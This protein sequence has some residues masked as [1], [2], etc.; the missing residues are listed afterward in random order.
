[1]KQQILFFLLLFIS[2]CGLAQHQN[3]EGKWKGVL[4][5]DTGQNRQAR[6][7]I[8][9]SIQFRQS[10]NAVWGIYVR[11][12]NA[13]IYSADC[14]GRLTAGL[15]NNRDSTIQIFQDGIEENKIPL[16]LCSYMNFLEADY[17]KDE[18]TEHL[19]G[20]WFGNPIA[21]RYGSDVASG[22]F[23]LEKISPVADIEV[24]KYFPNL[25]RLI[26]KFNSD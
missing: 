6:Q 5:L 17:S 19:K 21:R 11:G 9:F 23:K 25:A 12:K 10:G 15:G 3:L 8:E 1:M 13:D 7:E 14:T 26:K 20:R 24:D 16:D 18:N 4:T 2:L 22:T